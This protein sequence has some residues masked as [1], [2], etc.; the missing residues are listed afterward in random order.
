MSITINMTDTT[1]F[2]LIDCAETVDPGIQMVPSGSTG[3]EAG[4]TTPSSP[5]KGT[6]RDSPRIHWCFTWNNYTRRELVPMVPIFDLHCAKYVFQQECGSET[7]T[8]HIQGYFELKFKKRLSGLKKLFN[9][10]IRFIPCDNIDA[11]I[12]YCSDIEK[13]TPYGEIWNKNIEIPYQGED[14]PIKLYGWQE[15]LRHE[16]KTIPPNNRKI[17]WYYDKEGNKGKSTF[18]KWM[19][20]NYGATCIMGGEKKDILYHVTQSKKKEIILVDLPRSQKNLISFAAIEQIKNGHIFNEKYE[21]NATLFKPPHLVIFS[22]YEP[23]LDKM[24]RDRWDVRV[25]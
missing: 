3:E 20:F 22:N 10:K 1:D 14:L 15:K 17:I 16:L 24:S 8:D 6:P 7:G 11:S 12:N 5:V 25:I 21:S 4:N 2:V 9:T 18:C 19:A 23:M 13:R